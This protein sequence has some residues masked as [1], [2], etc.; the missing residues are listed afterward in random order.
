MESRNPRWRKW[1]FRCAEGGLGLLL[2]LWLAFPYLI[3]SLDLETRI[4]SLIESSFGG[5][6]T[7]EAIRLSRTGHV[8]LTGVTYQTEFRDHPLRIE[9]QSA[10]SFLFFYTRLW[11]EDL[12][13]RLGDNPFCVIPEVWIYYEPTVDDPQLRIFASQGTFYP[14]AIPPASE[15]QVSGT[16]PDLSM[17]RLVDLREWRIESPDLPLDYLWS[18]SAR[19]AEKIQ[20]SYKIQPTNKRGS[21]SGSVD[22][23]REGLPLSATSR[24]QRFPLLLP[25]AWPAQ[26]VLDGTAQAQPVESSGYNLALILTS[27][28]WNLGVAGMAIA[29]ASL[30]CQGKA[31]LDSAGLPLDL[32]LNLD[33]GVGSIRQ[34][35]ATWAIPAGHGRIESSTPHQT[36]DLAWQSDRVGAIHARLDPSD[37]AG[38]TA[39][40]RMEKIPLEGLLPIFPETLR[41]TWPS[42]GGIV[43]ASAAIAPDPEGQTAY[44]ASFQIEQGSY[45]EESLDIKT[46]SLHGSIQ[47]STATATLSLAVEDMGLTAAGVSIH[48]PSLTIQS[49]ARFNDLIQPEEIHIHTEHG[50]ST[51]GWG[52]QN[53]TIPGGKGFAEYALPVPRLIATWSS[54]EIGSVKA[55]WSL[56]PGEKSQITVQVG[57]KP[58]KRLG[59]LLPKSIQEALPTVEGLITAEGRL[60]FGETGMEGYQV[61]FNLEPLEIEIAGNRFSETTLSGTLSGTQKRLDATIQAETAWAYPL[62]ETQ[63]LA[64][65][66]N[67]LELTIQ[68]DLEKGQ[69]VVQGTAADLP[70]FHNIEAQ[71]A[72]GNEW[73]AEGELSFEELGPKLEQWGL[74]GGLEGLEGMGEGLLVVKGTGAQGRADLHSVDMALFSFASEPSYGLQ[75]RDVSAVVRWDPAQGSAATTLHAATPYFSYAGNDVEWPGEEFRLGWDKKDAQQTVQVHPPG[76]GKLEIRTNPKTGTDIQ[77]QDLAVNSVVVPLLTELHWGQEPD[78][79]TWDAGGEL[80]GALRWVQQDK[81]SLQ[82]TLTLSRGRFAYPGPPYIQ[83]EDVLISFPL[84]YP[85]PPDPSPS[86]AVQFKIGKIALRDEQFSAVEFVIP[87][88]AE[89]ISLPDVTMPVFKGAVRLES[90]RVRGWQSQ[91]VEMTG[92]I[93]LDQ[94][95]LPALNQVLPVFP[96]EGALSGKISDLLISSDV[97]QATGALQLSVFGGTMGIGEVSVRYPFSPLRTIGVD[98]DLEKIDLNQLT[99]Y[100]QFGSMSGTISGHMHDLL[101]TVPSAGSGEL[102]LPMRFDIEIHSDMKGNGS[103]NREALAKIVDLG[104]TSGFAKSMLDREK[105]QFAR[106]GLRAELDGDSLQLYGNLKNN[107]FLEP[108]GGWFTNKVAIMLG[109]P[110]QILSFSAFWERLLGQIDRFKTGTGAP[111]VKVE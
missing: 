33:H 57:K 106:L 18:L 51:V 13:V 45:Q 46:P 2:L 74:T 60:G 91:P 50:Q 76:G 5:T 11:M 58:V 31:T 82:G 35:E 96:E 102:P 79:R 19:F 26:I 84:H 78:E 39:T 25:A 62:T 7:I 71:W 110:K 109:N 42:G 63:T 52:E 16:A 12:Q 9:L 28:E 107:Y 89:E 66:R 15:N 48:A 77:I 4:P 105:Y 43:S 56:T 90:V 22:L 98:V 41:A 10:Q 30:A 88:T 6:C 81:S 69:G 34:N 55:D 73:K 1:L 92:S 101:F 85:V 38:I 40:L 44:A 59:A 67:P 20:F 23:S 68:W 87:Y 49:L 94:L 80:D 103:I 47:G 70:P 83:T 32:A 108:S 17:L 99:D 54:P 27:E 21:W 65:E 29:G 3:H 111:D 8:V 72:T 14:H 97:M 95:A 64:I 36:V 61:D 24:F 100:F 93:G 86:R 53:F 75:I 37:W 104:Q